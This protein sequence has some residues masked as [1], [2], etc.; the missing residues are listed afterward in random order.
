M[1]AYKIKKLILLVV[2]YIF[3][4]FIISAYG[5]VYNPLVEPNGVEIPLVVN[6]LGQQ[7]PN[8]V[9]DV[10]NFVTGTN[11][12][13]E[14]A[15]IQFSLKHINTDFNDIGDG[16]SLLTEQ[17][18]PDLLHRSL[19][20]FHGHHGID[21][22]LV[23]NI[24]N[25]VWVERPELVFWHD[26]FYP[27]AFLEWNRRPMQMAY[28]FTHEIGKAAGLQPSTEP[29]NLMNPNGLG[30][31]LNESQIAYILG[32]TKQVGLVRSP[33][34]EGYAADVLEE[35]RCKSPGSL[36]Y[37]ESWTLK[38]DFRDDVLLN[39]EP[40]PGGPDMEAFIAKAVRNGEVSTLVLKYYF[41]GLGLPEN[42]SLDTFFKINN[43]HAY[44]HGSNGMLEDRFNIY[45]AV[46][47]IN[48]SD[49]GPAYVGGINLKTVE[50]AFVQISDINVTYEYDFDQTKIKAEIPYNS[51]TSI[52]PDNLMESLNNGQKIQILTNAYSF[53]Y[54]PQSGYLTPEDYVENIKFKAI[55]RPLPY[56]PA[57]LS[58]NE[59]E[60]STTTGFYSYSVKPV[61]MPEP[62]Q[63]ISEYL[64]QVFN[65]SISPMEEG[66]RESQ[67]INYYDSSDDR[68]FFTEDNNYPDATYPID[69]LEQPAS[70]PGAGDDDDNFGTEITAAVYLTK[71]LHIF[72]APGKGAAF[73]E[74]GGVEV[75][76]AFSWNPPDI[77]DP[78][79]NDP[80]TGDPNSWEYQHDGDK[81]DEDETYILTRRDWPFNVESDGY[82][83]LRLRTWNQ[84]GDASL[85]MTEILKN[86][87]RVLVGDTDKGSS[88]VYLPT[89]INF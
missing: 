79:M 6:I 14:Q 16:D 12:I 41:N 65:G 1:E 21:K 54:N 38:K 2:F 85:E 71:G 3:F 13:L 32:L 17:E 30:T 76:S 48:L 50:Q 33:L 59:S 81:Y 35:L 18:I 31:L 44:D 55:P 89:N 27:V 63:P 23:L 88:P 80:N 87:N 69:V 37:P 82:Y 68:G 46:I 86:G 66:M 10:K 75:G 84:T 78:N 28:T 9:N 24:A 72:G 67:V 34:A 43:D 26:I 42:T 51:L 73:L 70:N 22:G 5:G 74:I 52:F 4:I 83:P 29:N 45:D 49:F 47:G 58:L 15:N 7:E 36:F 8:D 40:Y 11:L 64:E 61:D 20:S 39:D 19:D 25:D 56:I 53:I 62:N 57:S 77:N 60:V